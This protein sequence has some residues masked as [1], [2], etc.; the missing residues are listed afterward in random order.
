MLPTAGVKN[1][2]PTKE[3][4]WAEGL[5]KCQT[6][7]TLQRGVQWMECG[8]QRGVQWVWWFGRAPKQGQM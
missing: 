5:S 4:S 3:D 7:D 6:M 8:L 1:N 2:R